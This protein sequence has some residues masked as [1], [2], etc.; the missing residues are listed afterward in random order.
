M[1]QSNDQVSATYFLPIDH[2]KKFSLAT[3]KHIEHA[4]GRVHC[5]RWDKDNSAIPRP[6][7]IIQDIN[8][9][10][11]ALLTVMQA[12]GKVVPGL[13]SRKGHRAYINSLAVDHRQEI[14][15]DDA[16]EIGENENLA[17]E[18]SVAEDEAKRSFPNRWLHADTRDVLRKRKYEQGSNSEEE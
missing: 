8:K 17:T 9:V 16:V 14:V 7:R 5:P 2:E 12:K 6:D 4:Y 1:Q 15:A 11:F 18:V 10:Q 3:P 13:S